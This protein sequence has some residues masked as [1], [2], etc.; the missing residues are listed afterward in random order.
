MGMHGLRPCSIL[1]R[2]LWSSLFYSSFKLHAKWVDMHLVLCLAVRALYATA[3]VLEMI[4]RIIENQKKKKK[5]II[6]SH[7]IE[8]SNVI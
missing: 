5:L 7:S 4:L 1:F 3:R 6:G 2:V 8:L